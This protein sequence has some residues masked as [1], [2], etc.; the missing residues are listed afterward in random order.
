[1]LLISGKYL[2]L[3]SWWIPK[4]APGV[5]TWILFSLIF[6]HQCDFNTSTTIFLTFFILI[7]LAVFGHLIND[8]SDIESDKKAGKSNL[9]N[10]IGIQNKTWIFAGLL[11]IIITASYFVPNEIRLLIFIQVLLN[12]SYSLHPIRLK[13]R[14]WWSLMVTGLYERTV[15]YLII[16]FSIIPIQTML[17]Q[18]FYFLVLYLLWGLF[19]E[20]RNF[21]NGQVEDTENDIKAKLNTLA[22]AVNP[23]TLK[24][25]KTVFLSLELMTLIS[26]YSLWILLGGTTIIFFLLINVLIVLIHIITI[27]D[28]FYIKHYERF[29]DFLY[30]Y[31][32]LSSL[33]IYCLIFDIIHPALGIGFLLVFISNYTLATL[34]FIFNKIF[35]VGSLIVNNGFYYLRKI[36]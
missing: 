34:K 25:V 30:C 6:K 18:D 26:W 28:L 15:P 20:F 17:H 4:I 9:F 16:I 5:F 12:C 8:Y 23:S 27:K 7:V 2:K 35:F 14:G 32:F 29:I 13:E 21:I 19:W 31:S 11:I 22:I 24:K 36:F 10:K 3:H 1:M 33:L